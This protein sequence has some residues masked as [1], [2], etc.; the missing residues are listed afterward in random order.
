MHGGIPWQVQAAWFVI[1]HL[2]WIGGGLLALLAY[3]AWRW[4]RK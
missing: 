1:D 3:G 4:W 2:F